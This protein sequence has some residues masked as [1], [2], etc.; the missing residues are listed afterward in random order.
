MSFFL[1]KRLVKYPRHSY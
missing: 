1:L